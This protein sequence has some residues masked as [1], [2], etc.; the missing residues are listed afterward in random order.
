[1]ATVEYLDEYDSDVDKNDDVEQIQET[2]TK[3]KRAKNYEYECLHSFSTEADA[4][5]WLN[6]QNLWSEF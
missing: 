5:K 1:M 6:D 3:R 4:I 2:S